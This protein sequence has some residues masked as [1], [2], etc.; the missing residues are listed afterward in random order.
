M[1]YNRNK[2]TLCKLLR[3]EHK[4]SKVTN[5]YELVHNAR[6]AFSTA[7]GD[8]DVSKQS[9]ELR[10][11]NNEHLYTLDAEDVASLALLAQKGEVEQFTAW[12]KGRETLVFRLKPKAQPKMLDGSNP[13]ACDLTVNDTKAFAGLNGTPNQFQI[14]RWMGYGL[15]PYMRQIA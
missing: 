15:I 3:S 9:A 10:N 7:R 11:D 12:K 8:A 14:E 4:C 2:I 5:G 6:P 13:T 1:L